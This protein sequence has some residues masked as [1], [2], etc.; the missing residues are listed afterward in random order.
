MRVLLLLALLLPGCTTPAWNGEVSRWGTLREVLRDGDTRGRVR[1]DGLTGR[2]LVGVGALRDL[3]GEVTVVEGRVWVARPDERGE[4]AAAL[5]D[6]DEAAFLAVAD[7]PRWSEH[8]TEGP[9]D[10][11]AIESRLAALADGRETVP[12]VVEGELRELDA[13]VLNGACPFAADPARRG[14]PVR[15]HREGVR[16]RLV[17]FF[18]TLP[19][20]TLTHHG[21]RLHVHVILDEGAITGHV[22]D[23]VI[24]GTLRVPAH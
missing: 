20:G 7:V 3:E 8:R 21:T 6:D 1:L 22:D 24:D 14:E 23:A 15:F 9:S 2:G 4:I 17:G 11:P 18:T 16:G 5:S 19:A 10:L 13:H 12:F